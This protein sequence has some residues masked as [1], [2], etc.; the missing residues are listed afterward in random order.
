MPGSGR[1]DKARFLLSGLG[2]PVGFVPVDVART[3]LVEQATEM[4]LRSPDLE[5]LPVC[6][7]FTVD[8]EKW[9]LRFLPPSGT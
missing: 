1:G 5:V 2:R 7:D 6:T 4:N 3:Q 9:R 8:F